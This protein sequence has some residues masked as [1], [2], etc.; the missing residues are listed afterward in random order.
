MCICFFL[1]FLNV[2]KTDGGQH[3]HN[4]P[5][6]V[7]LQ[8]SQS[9]VECNFR[10]SLVSNSWTKSVT[11]YSPWHLSPLDNKIHYH[12]TWPWH[13]VLSSH[14]R[15]CC[16][17]GGLTQL[18]SNSC[19]P[20]IFLAFLSHIATLSPSESANWTLAG[21]CVDLRLHKSNG[22]SAE[23]EVYIHQQNHNITLGL[24]WGWLVFLAARAILLKWKYTFFTANCKK[25]LHNKRALKPP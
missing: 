24:F 19:K 5:T 21:W 12:Q 2:A 8:L 14:V 15:T 22:G 25:E 4:N 20:I 10:H 9:S 17:I 11:N 18:P 23:K 1:V 6:C 3:S 13:F 7:T 16:Y